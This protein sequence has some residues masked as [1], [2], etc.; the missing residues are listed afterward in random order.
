MWN[1]DDTSWMKQLS[2]E[3]RTKIYNVYKPNNKL[4]VRT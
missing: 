2:N 1:I 4:T 3:T